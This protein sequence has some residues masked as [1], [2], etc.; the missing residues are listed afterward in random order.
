MEIKKLNMLKNPIN[1][2]IKKTDPIW[3]TGTLLIAN[4]TTALCAESY[5]LCSVGYSFT[6]WGLIGLLGYGF[7][8]FTSMKEKN[9]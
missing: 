8:K 4:R 9:E 2:L 7:Y 6:G 3:L 1:N 5:L